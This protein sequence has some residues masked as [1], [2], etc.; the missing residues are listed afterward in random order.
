MPLIDDRRSSRM[1]PIQDLIA[2]LANGAKLDGEIE[3]HEQGYAGEWRLPA[4][5]PAVYRTA[6]RSPMF[7]TAS[8][9]FE[10]MLSE[11]NRFAQ[12]QS[13]Q[14]DEIDN[15][16]NDPFVNRAAQQQ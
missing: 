1:I 15:P 3:Q 16:C 4:I 8:D 6:H 5:S 10:W 7:P 13:S 14:V 2:I 12:S 11:A 9:C